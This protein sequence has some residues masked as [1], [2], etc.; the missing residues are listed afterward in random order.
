MSALLNIDLASEERTAFDN[1]KTYLLQ[2]K[3]SSIQRRDYTK[4]GE[5]NFYDASALEIAGAG[6][7]IISNFRSGPKAEDFYFQLHQNQKRL[8]VQV[9]IASIEPDDF[10]DKVKEILKAVGK[11]AGERLNQNSHP[12]VTPFGF[13]LWS[14]PGGAKTITNFEDSISEQIFTPDFRDY[15]LERTFCLKFRET[16]K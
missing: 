12:V 4:P 1:L 3:H 2:S 15:C 5:F 6:K 13:S 7:T 10:I 11:T 9:L 16:E 8:Q 14:M